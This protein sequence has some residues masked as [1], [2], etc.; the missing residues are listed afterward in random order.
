MRDIS[1]D[2]EERPEV[3]NLVL[4]TALCLDKSLEAPSSPPNLPV[5][6]A[7]LNPRLSTVECDW[8]QSV[9]SVILRSNGCI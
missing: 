9:Q 3:S 7:L 2:P 1:Y 4:V 8:H 6:P 5:N